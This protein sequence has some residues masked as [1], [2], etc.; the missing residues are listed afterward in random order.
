M[1]VL[2]HPDY[3]DDVAIVALAVTVLRNL[4]CVSTAPAVAVAGAAGPDGAA[5]AEEESPSPALAI[6]LCGAAAELEAAMEKFPHAANVQENGRCALYNLL[7]LSA[8]DA[9]RVLDRVDALQAETTA[10]QQEVAALR[11]SHGQAVNPRVSPL[12]YDGDDATASPHARNPRAA[13]RSGAS[14]PAQG[15]MHSRSGSTA[16]GADPLLTRP[17]L[18]VPPPSSPAATPAASSVA[19]G[20]AGAYGH[21]GARRSLQA[22]GSV[23]SHTD[24]QPPHSVQ[25]RSLPLSS[26]PLG[27]LF[28]SSRRLSGRIAV[29]PMS[30]AHTPLPSTHGG[31]SVG[32]VV[33]D[34]PPLSGPHSAAS[35]P[36]S[37]ALSIPEHAVVPWHEVSAGPRP[38]HALLQARLQLMWTRVAVVALVIAVVVLA[39]VLGV[40]G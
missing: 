37:V 17:V 24:S 21:A 33:V 23:S 8:T 26:T 28:S 16:D 9:R 36:P 12:P 11:A 22:A 30:V 20:G 35:S 4:A 10:L 13:R 34:V 3:A 15:V 2:R 5:A 1:E 32:A 29:H 18:D 27:S 39:A 7:L 38:T 6:A 19:G 31:D 14:A 40:R 25:R